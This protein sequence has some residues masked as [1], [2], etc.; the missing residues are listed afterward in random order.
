MSEQNPEEPQQRS[1]I[2][3]EEDGIPQS[4]MREPFNADVLHDQEDLEAQE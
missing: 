1:P 2:L 4:D 3:L